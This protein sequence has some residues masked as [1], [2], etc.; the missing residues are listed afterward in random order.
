MGSLHLR[1]VQASAAKLLRP[2]WERGSFAGDGAD[3][4]VYLSSCMLVGG[5]R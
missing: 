1:Q 3:D 2:I 4:F 5:Y